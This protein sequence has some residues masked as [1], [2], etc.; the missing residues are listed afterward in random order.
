MNITSANDF[1][2]KDD[3]TYFNANLTLL[4]NIGEVFGKISIESRG[5]FDEVDLKGIR[6]IRNRIVHD[7]AGIDSFRIYEIILKFI[8][9]LKMNVISIT[10]SYLTNNIVDTNEYQL[11]K[12]SNYYKHVPFSIIL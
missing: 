10:K 5:H 7:Y 2:E 9:K 11:S 4:T 6:S 12:N 1:I 3:Q 8:P